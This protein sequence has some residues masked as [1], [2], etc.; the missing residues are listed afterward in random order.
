MTNFRAF[1][2]TCGD[3]YPF[4]RRLNRCACRRRECTSGCLQRARVSTDRY[5]DRPFRE[6]W[7][8]TT[9]EW[10]TSV[11]WPLPLFSHLIHAGVS[12]EKRRIVVRYCRRRR[13]ERVR[14]FGVLHEVIDEHSSNVF[15][16]E[17]RVHV[18]AT[19]EKSSGRQK[20]KSKAH[21][22]QGDA[23]SERKSRLRSSRFPDWLCCRR[24]KVPPSPMTTRSFCTCTNV[25]FDTQRMA[26]EVASSLFRMLP[27]C[28]TLIGRARHKIHCNARD[29]DR[30]ISAADVFAYR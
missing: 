6:I 15:S 24:R 18:F 19:R 12:E 28:A 29:G 14:T 21:M 22:T 20:G 9:N 16:R 23:R 7:A 26:C 4:R 8:C 1:R 27:I 11:E 5:W 30:W 2:R 10:E 13:D 25:F 17:T 3:T